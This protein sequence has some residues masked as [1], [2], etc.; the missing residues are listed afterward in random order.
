MLEKLA[1]LK[2]AFYNA[3]ALITASSR[4]TSVNTSCAA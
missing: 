1:L 4:L 3:P 2:M